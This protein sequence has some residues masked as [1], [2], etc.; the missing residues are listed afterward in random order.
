MTLIFCYDC[1]YLVPSLFASHVIRYSAIRAAR[2]YAFHSA[3][4][5]RPITTFRIPRYTTTVTHAT[6]K[7]QAGNNTTP[8]LI[9]LHYLLPTYTVRCRISVIPTSLPTAHCSTT[10]ALTAADASVRGLPLFLPHTFTFTTQAFLS[11]FSPGNASPYGVAIARLQLIAGDS[12]VPHCCLSGSA[13][14]LI[15]CRHREHRYGA[16][17]RHLRLPLPQ[18]LLCLPRA[19]IIA[20]RDTVPEEVHIPHCV[21][22]APAH[23]AGY[24]DVPPLTARHR[25]GRL[26]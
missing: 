1:L 22:H 3:T 26:P 12:Y 24:A 7:L 5:E 17:L 13:G 16:N 2:Y 15:L 4:V 21:L 20:L 9:D 19:Y 18:G 23:D 6:F 8:K 11:L 14:A 10:I 25:L